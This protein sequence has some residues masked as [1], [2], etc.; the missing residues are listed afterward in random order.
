MRRPLV[1]IPTYHL[2]DGRVRGWPGDG[3]G[4]P[5]RYIACLERAGARALLLPGPDPEG[6]AAA[7]EPFDGLLLVGGADIDPARY[8]ADP[9][10]SVYGVDAGRDE[11]E[12]GVAV[13]A[14]E[15]GMPVLGICRGFQLLNVAL[16]GTLH[17]HLPDLE[18]WAVHGSPMTGPSA[19]HDVK[20][21]GGSR[22]AA[23]CGTDV[24]VSVSHHHQGVDRLGRGL[25]AVGW[26]G[27]GLVEAVEHE[28]ARWV[29]AV[30]WH[31]EMS[32]ADDPTQQALFDA[33]V[34]QL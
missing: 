12:L 1:A 7:L 18:G 30:Q 3:Y 2:E 14:V 5:S 10:P 31:P 32:A 6:P 8:G 16:G 11:L 25:R 23:A 28:E 34:A 17:Q 20:V 22:I 4:V 27:D 29:V 26:T 21:E 24:L 9:H 15:H 19:V 13:E 33:F